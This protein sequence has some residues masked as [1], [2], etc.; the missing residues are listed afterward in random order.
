M[1]NFREIAETFDAAG[2]WRE[3]AGGHRDLVD[4]PAHRR[5][6]YSQPFSQQSE[7]SKIHWTSADRWCII[8]RS[9]AGDFK[10]LGTDDEIRQHD[11]TA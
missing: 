4:D 7:P 5:G 11:D 3:E 2:A 6:V 1:E 8:T 10:M 9:G